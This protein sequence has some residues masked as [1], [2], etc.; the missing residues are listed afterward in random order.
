MTTGDRPATTRR[1]PDRA[2]LL[3]ALA[4]GAAG[5]VVI[6]DAA[7]LGGAATY[8]RVGPK[9][10]PYAVGAGLLLLAAGTA[11]KAWR[12]NFPP[13]DRDLPAPILW[14]VGGLL[15]QMLAISWV[16]FAVATGLMFAAVARG[17]GRG[18][19]WMTVPL[20]IAI[21]LAIYLVFALVLQLSLPAGPIERIFV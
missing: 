7:Q 16:G 6:E 19:L 2:A 9:A 20:G 4:L 12:G 5:V 15:V 1:R 8:A 11:V 21:S 10:F 14:I 18:P 17:F 3:I 13:R